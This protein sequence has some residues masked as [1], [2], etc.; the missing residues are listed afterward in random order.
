MSQHAPTVDVLMLSYCKSPREYHLTLSSLSALFFSE[1]SVSFRVVLVET[2]SRKT[3]EEWSD[4][5]LFGDEVE[6]VFPAEPFHYNQFLRYGFGQ[7]TA[8]HAPYLLISNNDV[9][10]EANSVSR[11]IGALD[12][13]HSVSPWCPGHHEPHFSL[14]QSHYEGYRTCLELC[15]W[16]IMFRRGILETVSFDELF[17]L[18]FPFWFQDDYYGFQLQRHGLRHALVRDARAHHLFSQSHELVDS[19]RLE[20]VT[21][22]AARVFAEKTAEIRQSSSEDPILTVAIPAR[23]GDLAVEGQLASLIRRVD[24]QVE[25]HPVEVLAL[26]DNGTLDPVSQHWQLQRWAQGRFVGFLTPGDEISADY[27]SAQLDALRSSPQADGIQ[28]R[29]PTESSSDCDSTPAAAGAASTSVDAWQVGCVRSDLVDSWKRS[30]D[31]VLDRVDDAGTDGDF[32]EAGHVPFRQAIQ[33]DR[34]LCR[35]K[36]DETWHVAGPPSDGE[37]LLTICVLTLPSRIDSCCAELARKLARQTAGRPVEVLILLDN[38]SLT[39]G[40]KR[41]RLL[42]L[43]RGRYISF[44]DDDDDISDDYVESLLKATAEDPD[45]IV[46]EAWVTL[47]GQQ[48]RVC[49]Y[50]MEFDNVDLEEEYLRVPDQKCCF[51]RELVCDVPFEDI[52]WQEDFRWA[53][54]VRPRLNSQV[55]I[56]RILY[57]YQYDSL[58]S[59]SG[60]VEASG[61]SKAGTGDGRPS[62]DATR[63]QQDRI[64]RSDIGPGIDVLPSELPIFGFWHIALMPGWREI[65]SDQ[66]RKLYASGLYA[67]TQRIFV[68]LAGGTKSDFDIADDKL[69]VAAWDPDLGVGEF[70]T[71][72]Y[73]YQFCRQH[74][75]LV[76]YIHTKGISRNTDC[77]TDW[78]HLMDHF[79]IIRHEECARQLERNDACGVNWLR[80]PLPHF[81]GNFWWSKSSH[82]RKLPT[83]EEHAERCD[84]M[85]FS[86]F[87]IL[88]WWSCEFWIGADPDIR[89][90]SLHESGVDHYEARYPRSRYTSL[91]DVEP[92]AAFHPRSAWRGLENQF[93]ILLEPIGDIRTVVE[94]GV[95][96]GYSL[97]CLASALPDASISGV[98]PYEDVEDAERDRF[99]ALKDQA[100]LGSMTAERWVRSHLHQFPNVQ[101]IKETGVRVAERFRAPIDVVHI[102]A[103]H[104]FDAVQCDF[105]A[106][107]PLLRPGGCILFHDT[108]SFAD[109]VGRFFHGLPGFKTEIVAGHG[110]GA[111]YKPWSGSVASGA[112]PQVVVKGKAI[113]DESQPVT[114]PL[115]IGQPFSVRSR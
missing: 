74:D 49:R 34:A 102:D 64:P 31:D 42:Q 107:E 89:V 16:A 22:E 115:T 76:Y 55:R 73:V 61:R 69:T 101:L 81:S 51:R 38:K 52:S 59:E 30:A 11:M 79:V 105:Q 44:I 36:S 94:V 20:K 40:T 110:L 88:K 92:T 109:D 15:G 82:I 103:V 2:A 32:V 29:M 57:R 113:A 70:P 33:M 78:R 90:A 53:A 85:Q 58:R 37:L 3:L 114:R 27:I 93:Q 95:E 10:F 65:V 25:N 66:L 100:V 111:W 83:L 99:D 21:T 67:K 63:E 80:E 98:D 14:D 91:K 35:R 84:G 62:S 77:T 19:E 71:L 60:T 23:F 6:T 50:G 86:G 9:I 112:V 12:E 72:D 46:F 7:L 68:G 39:I 1:T 13:Y 18:D 5:Q 96:F 24:E 97:F 87:K 54:A 104:T 106:W 48:G 45:C 43:A 8:P 108:R 41:T 4:G 17:P 28:W 26:I 47:D 75:A 56:P